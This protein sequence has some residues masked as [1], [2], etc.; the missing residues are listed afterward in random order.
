MTNRLISF[1]ILLIIG[2]LSLTSSFIAWTS[3]TN[4]QLSKA[5]SIIGQVTYADTRE[6]EKA[7]FRYKSYKR[8]FYFKIKNSDQNFAIYR[9]YEGYE[10]L[11]SEIHAG[12]TLKIYYRES[13]LDYNTHIF[14]VEKDN[15]V[16]QDYKDYQNQASSAA[17]I[18]LFVG[19]LLTIGSILWYNNF[20][21]LK[22]MT[23]W[24][25]R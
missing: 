3:D 21:L 18:T 22:F 8:V 13:S 16:L 24:V 23:S 10:D 20:N 7:N 14:Q 15:K 4:I 6:I 11:K 25:E 1:I 2:L 5:K 19:L 9:S 12:D 17:G